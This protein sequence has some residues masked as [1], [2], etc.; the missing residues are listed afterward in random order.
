[1]KGKQNSIDDADLAGDERRQLPV[2]ELLVLVELLD[3]LDGVRDLWPEDVDD[4]HVLVEGL[5]LVGRVVAVGRHELLQREDLEL[6]QRLVQQGQYTTLKHDKN[7]FKGLFDSPET[8]DLRAEVRAMVI[9]E[10]SRSQ[11]E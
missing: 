11:I 2:L 5:D 9:G 1:M 4:G 10:R 8:F 3:R 7:I 6:R